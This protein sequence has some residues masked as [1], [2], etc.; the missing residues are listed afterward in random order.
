[1]TITELIDQLQDLPQDA[2]IVDDKFDLLD[3]TFKLDYYPVSGYSSYK[4]VV[5]MQAS[6]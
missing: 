1:M 4:D 6:S 3:Y 2:L 5:I